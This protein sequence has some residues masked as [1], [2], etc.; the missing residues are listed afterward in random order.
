[1]W[2][3]YFLSIRKQPLMELVMVSLVPLAV[4]VRRGGSNGETLSAPFST[5]RTAAVRCR[6]RASLAAP[7]PVTA[8]LKP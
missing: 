6:S 2:R 5:I 8:A 4:P 1:M 7:L 3:I